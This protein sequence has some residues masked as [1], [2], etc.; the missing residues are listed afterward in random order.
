MSDARR[1]VVSLFLFL[2]QNQAGEKGHCHKIDREAL[3][4]G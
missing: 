1:I 2:L 4:G 3:P